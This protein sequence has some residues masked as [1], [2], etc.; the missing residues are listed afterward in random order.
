[1]DKPKH[2]IGDIVTHIYLGRKIR[3][4]A[5]SVNKEGNGYLYHTRERWT[6]RLNSGIPAK[7]VY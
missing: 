7:D 6:G 2:M 3:I 5:I 4:D 1:M